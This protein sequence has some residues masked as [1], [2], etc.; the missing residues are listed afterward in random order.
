MLELVLVEELPDCLRTV[1]A[2]LLGLIYGT[3]W[4][5]LVESLSC[6]LSVGSNGWWHS[7]TLVRFTTIARAFV[8]LCLCHGSVLLLVMVLPG[9]ACE[10]I[11]LE[12]GTCFFR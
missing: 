10:E 5:C 4:R 12:L 9:D 3:T 11:E 1:L 7:A 6:S 8:L 2:L